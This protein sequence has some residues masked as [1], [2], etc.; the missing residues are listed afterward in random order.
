VLKIESPIAETSEALV[1]GHLQLSTSKPRLCLAN[2][3][4]R[5]AVNTP[6]LR[7]SAALA[8]PKC[9]E[10]SAD[11]R[12]ALRAFREISVAVV[13]D[14]AMARLHLAFM[15]VAGPTD[16]LTFDHGEIVISAETAARNAQHYGHAVEVEIALYT[17]H[18]FL[19]L[20][21][22]DDRA[23]RDAARMR[24]AQSGVLR[25]CQSQL[26]IP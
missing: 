3:Q 9:L 7:R 4:R 5:V 8:L 2:R 15:D 25:W 24:R 13:S 14:P 19:H 18:G 22:F 12:F 26:P 23:A 21:G 20:N 16:V 10:L 11:D 6:W 1:K 17:I